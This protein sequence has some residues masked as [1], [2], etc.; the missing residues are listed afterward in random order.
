[1][2]NL[3]NRFKKDKLENDLS[4]TNKNEGNYEKWLESYLMNNIWNEIIL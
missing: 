4:M 1:M 2:N 3:N